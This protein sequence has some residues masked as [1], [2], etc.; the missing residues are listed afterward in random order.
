MPSDNIV[1]LTP[2]DFKGTT[3]PKYKDKIVLIKFY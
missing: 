3:L 1:I 2:K